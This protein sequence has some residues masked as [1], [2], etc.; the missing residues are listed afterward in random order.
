LF[1]LQALRVIV[2]MSSILGAPEWTSGGVIPQ[3]SEESAI[4]NSIDRKTI[5]PEQSGGRP[6]FLGMR[7][8]IMDVFR[9]CAPG[10]NAR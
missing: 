6:F 5:N 8:S 1:S 2:P 10:L 4:T 7:T 9:W 3:F